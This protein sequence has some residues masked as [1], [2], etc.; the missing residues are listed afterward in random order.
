MGE[1]LRAGRAAAAALLCA[2]ICLVAVPVAA[3]APATAECGAPLL[4]IGHGHPVDLA[5]ACEAWRR[6]S[7][8]L[9][10]EHGLRLKSPV[11]LVFA[12]RV[13]LDLGP[14]KF[15]VLGLNDAA[16]RTIHITS[17]TAAWL[18][19][20]DR[21]MF[22]QQMDEELHVSLIV[23]ELAHAILRDSYRPGGPPDLVCAEYVAY[24]TQF[25]TME[26]AARERVLAGYPPG[27]FASPDEIT[28][29]CLMMTPHEFGVRAWRHYVRVG[30]RDMLQAIVEG[31]FRVP[32]DP[33]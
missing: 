2:W 19:E 30:H 21:L 22:R 11:A 7:R 26:P 28:Q 29:V 13:E 24:V 20:P 17:M 16:T 4:R 32:E 9:F 27:D 12:E 23:H 33:W 10:E 1:R 14:E 8:F 15:R 25:A 18:R 3:E 31:R 6:V 5:H